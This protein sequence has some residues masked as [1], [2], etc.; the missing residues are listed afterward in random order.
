[1]AEALRDTDMPFG[2]V[3]QPMALRRRVIATDLP[4]PGGAFGLTHVAVLLAAEAQPVALV[5][6]RYRSAACAR[7]EQRPLR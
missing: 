2:L 6:E 7:L 5:A 3:V 1:M 4:P